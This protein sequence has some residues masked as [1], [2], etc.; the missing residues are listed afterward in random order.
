L[1]T[2]QNV[3]QNGVTAARSVTATGAGLTFQW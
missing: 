3:C 1:T 2:V